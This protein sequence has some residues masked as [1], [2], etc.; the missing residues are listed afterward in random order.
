MFFGIFEGVRKNYNIFS[1]AFLKFGNRN[2]RQNSF[3]RISRCNFP[4]FMHNKISLCKK[5]FP[6]FKML[7]LGK[8]FCLKSAKSADFPHFICFRGIVFNIETKVRCGKLSNT[9]KIHFS[10]FYPKTLH[11]PFFTPFLLFLFSAAFFSANKFVIFTLILKLAII[12]SLFAVF[13]PRFVLFYGF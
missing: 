9:K 1:C 3:L 11:F 5:S 8:T 4:V 10:V 2:E 13:C 7:V 12:F 6:Q